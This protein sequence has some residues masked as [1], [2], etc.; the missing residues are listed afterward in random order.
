MRARGSRRWHLSNPLNWS[1]G[2]K[3]WLVFGISALLHSEYVIWTWVVLNEPVTRRFMDHAETRESFPLVT[4]LAVL[5]WTLFLAMAWIRR[6]RPE[7]VVHEYACNLYYGLS[8]CVFSYLSGTLTMA[9]GV[10]L[11]GAPVLGFILFRTRPI[12]WAM[13][14]ALVVQV[15]LSV[16][17]ASGWWSYAPPI[18]SPVGANG[19]LSGFWLASMYMFVLPH[20]LVITALSWYV[21]SGWRRREDAIRQLSLTDPVTQLANRRAIIARLEHEQESSARTRR[22]LSVI[23]VD[24]DYFKQIND[25]HGHSAGDLALRAAGQRLSQALR[26]SDHLGRFGG[27]EFLMVLPGTDPEGARLLAERCRA[28]LATE[29][30]KTADGNHIT[31]TASLGLYCNA[32]NWDDSPDAM[33]RRADQSLFRAK[34]GGRNQVREPSSDEM[35]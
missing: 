3:S 12:L 6:V 26:Q 17:A 29:P 4:T 35:A 24:L 9:T 25:S 27:E 16:G 19:Q 34:E 31:L 22:P 30:V 21:L 33:L 15:V 7:S 28:A 10:V 8:L 5:S 20:L 1:P 23:M 32:G 18:S 11:A 13:G 14:T 2:D